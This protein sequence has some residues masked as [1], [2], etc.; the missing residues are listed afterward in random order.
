MLCLENMLDEEAIRNPL[1]DFCHEDD[2][3]LQTNIILK[4]VAIIFRQ[5]LTFFLTI[6]LKMFKIFIYY[7]VIIGLPFLRLSTEIVPLKSQ[8]TVTV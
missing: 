3:N 4:G 6:L 2:A 7:S 5:M 1:R 8:N